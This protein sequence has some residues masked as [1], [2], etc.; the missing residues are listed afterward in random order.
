MF[1]EPAELFNARADKRT[2][3]YSIEHYTELLKL[4][5]RVTDNLL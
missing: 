4:V 3:A 2:T 5:G 1:K